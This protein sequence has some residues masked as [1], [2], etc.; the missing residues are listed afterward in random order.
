MVDDSTLII[1]RTRFSVTSGKWP[2]F[3]PDKSWLDFRIDLFRKCAMRAMRKQSYKD[4][5]WLIETSLETSNYVKEKLGDCGRV[6]GHIVA[7]EGARGE[8]FSALSE[9]AMGVIP[10]SYYY[11]VTRL[12]SDDVLHPKTLESYRAHISPDVPLVGIDKG[13]KF[14][15]MSGDMFIHHYNDSA[16]FGLLCADKKG[17][18][19]PGGHKTIRRHY[20][21]ISLT[22]V[23]FIQV[24]H[25]TN[26]RAGIV[27]GDE[28]VA[29]CER[30][31]IL[32]EYGIDWDPSVP[33]PNGESNPQVVLRQYLEKHEGTK[34]TNNPLG[35]M[36]CDTLKT[37]CRVVKSGR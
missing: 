36:I 26:V 17:L 6:N 10:D 34:G 30:D 18:I 32:D 20:N 7:S 14:D 19:G 15:W 5:V 31:G 13:Y 22:N 8:G 28:E 21:H 3:V 4:Y 2:G 33:P 29:K 24:I 16:F 1:V 37:A 11:I 23:P 9:E 25:H 12:D 27:D 35:K